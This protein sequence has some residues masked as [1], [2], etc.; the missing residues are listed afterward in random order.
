LTVNI[1]LVF[2]H[3]TDENGIDRQYWFD[4][5]HSTDENGID[6][7][8]RPRGTELIYR[9]AWGRLPNAGTANTTAPPVAAP[10]CV[11]VASFP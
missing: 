4:I 6:R 3:N 11:P 8:Y 9:L 5:R 1:A 10:L 2:W 7:Q